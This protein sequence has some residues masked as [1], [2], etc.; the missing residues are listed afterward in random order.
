MASSLQVT[1]SE[2]FDPLEPANI[3]EPFRFFKNLRT[4]QPVYWNEKYSF[5]MLTRYKDIKAA[6]LAPQ[7]F[8]SVTKTALAKWRDKIPQKAQASFDYGFQFIFGHLQASDPPAHTAQRQAVMKAFMPLVNGV[9][10]TSLERRVSALLDEMERAGTCDFVKDFA[11]PLPS[12][13]IFDLLGVPA[14]YHEIIRESS[15]MSVRFPNAVYSC[16]GDALEKIAEKTKLARTAL[17]ELVQQKRREPQE[18]LIS[19]LVS[20]SS[21][22]DQMPEEEIVT[23]CNFLLAAGHETTAN[24]LAGSLRYL[25]Q[26][27]KQWEQLAAR[28]DLL[29]GAVEEL[30]RFVSPVLWLARITTEDIELDGHILPKDSQVILG[31]GSANHDPDQFEDPET[32]DVT[33]KNVHSLALGYGIHTCLGAALAKMETQVA[34]AALLRRVPDIQL[35]TDEFEYKP[36][37]FLRALKSLPVAVHG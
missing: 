23:L 24:L 25:L 27:R 31:F 12:R 6:L 18:D 3:Q 36:V 10:K 11:Y 30:L 29:P 5:W 1:E 7:K 13:V 35:L 22:I 28:P 37:Y 33:R 19:L 4:E 15:D 21:G 26:D 8:S 17:T 34:L 9:V 20:E 14:E 16:D 2:I 32:L